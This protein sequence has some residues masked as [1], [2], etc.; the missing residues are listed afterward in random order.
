MLRPASPPKVNPWKGE[1]A[2]AA[3]LA[4]LADWPSVTPYF[5]LQVVDESDGTSLQ[6]PITIDLTLAAPS[7][8]GSMVQS[9]PVE[10]A[11]PLNGHRCARRHFCSASSD[12]GTDLQPVDHGMSLSAPTFEL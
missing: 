11:V 4:A 9:A 12:A 6:D 2:A 1:R 3:V 5:E 10:A 8:V 7:S